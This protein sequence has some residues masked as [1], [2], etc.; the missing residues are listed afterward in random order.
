MSS[1][2]RLACFDD[3]WAKYSNFAELYPLDF[4]F[5]DSTR[6]LNRLDSGEQRRQDV[7]VRIP[8]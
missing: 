7:L 1:K 5:Q 6:L 8:F 4:A 2:N 3:S